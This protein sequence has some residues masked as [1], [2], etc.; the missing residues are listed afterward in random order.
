MGT[1]LF[2][3]TMNMISGLAFCT[4]HDSHDMEYLPIRCSAQRRWAHKNST[5]L[6]ACEVANALHTS[7]RACYLGSTEP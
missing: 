7:S 6:I 3:S 2:M 5:L 4:A 1:D